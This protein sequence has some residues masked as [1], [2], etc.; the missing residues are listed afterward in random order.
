MS[1]RCVEATW[2]VFGKCDGVSGE[3]KE[4]QLKARYP[5]QVTSEQIKPG[6]VQSG[7]V[8]SGEVK[9]GKV[10]RSSKVKTV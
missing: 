9:L 10:I 3:F 8:Y 1:E 5:G 2:K 7:Q 4:S 6:Q